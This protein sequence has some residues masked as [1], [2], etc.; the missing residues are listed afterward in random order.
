MP[1]EVNDLV[2]YDWVPPAEFPTLTGRLEPPQ[3][4]EIVTLL[5]T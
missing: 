1:Y 4:G 2:G 3:L 5:G